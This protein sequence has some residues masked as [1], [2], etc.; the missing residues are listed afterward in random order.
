MVQAY[1]TGVE[2]ALDTGGDSPEAQ[3]LKEIYD[4]LLR[5]AEDAGDDLLAFVNRANAAALFTRLSEGLAKANVAAQT[6]GD[7]SNPTMG[8]DGVIRTYRRLYERVKDLPYAEEQRKAYEAILEIGAQCRSASEF[9][10]RITESGARRRLEFAATYDRAKETYDRAEANDT[11]TRMAAMQAMQAAQTARTGDELTYQS[12][13]SGYLANAEAI[14]DDLLFSQIARL[15]SRIRDYDE[16]KRALRARR[17]TRAEFVFDLLKAKEQAARHYRLMIDRLGVDWATIV[18]TPRAVRAVLVDREYANGLVWFGSSPENLA[19]YADILENEILVDDVP[20][21]ALL[22]RRSPQAYHPL[23]DEETR[24]GSTVEAHALA[25]LRKLAEDD[26]FAWVH[27]ETQTIEASRPGSGDGP[28]STDAG[29]GSSA[30]G[31]LGG[32]PAMRIA[33][34][35]PPRFAYSAESR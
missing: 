20:I 11:Y 21:E 28:S 33:A 8:L 35:H 1:K 5:V 10:M 25:Y 34:T 9:E 7:G 3:A 15:L 22:S 16:T 12:V 24:S 17:A 4:E 13:R 14:R 30:D 18:S 19:W 31:A 6:G 23:P 32:T 2:N 26:R 27:A 29:A